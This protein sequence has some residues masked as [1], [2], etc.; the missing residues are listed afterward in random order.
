MER[1][2]EK[3]ASLLTRPLEEDDAGPAGGSPRVAPASGSY[4]GFGPDTA[5]VVKAAGMTM[6]EFESKV[7]EAGGVAAAAVTRAITASRG[8]REVNPPRL[9]VEGDADAQAA[10]EI[11]AIAK[12]LAEEAGIP[13]PKVVPRRSRAKGGDRGVGAPD[14]TMEG[15]DTP[16][17]ERT[18][19]EAESPGVAMAEGVLGV[20]MDDLREEDMEV[21][22]ESM[23]GDD[24]G[25]EN[26]GMGGCGL[27]A[28]V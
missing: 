12:E 21:S 2:R 10:A 23:V 26:R 22:N 17:A 19:G 7:A 27:W 4:V 25:V 3:F 6:K 28:G 16:G 18:L 8:G 14:V 11:A 9:T 20:G 5:A 15:G 24:L 13:A 1:A